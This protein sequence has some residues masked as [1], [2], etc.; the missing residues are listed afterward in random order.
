M[1][2]FGEWAMD[3]AVIGTERGVRTQ[4]SPVPSKLAPP[5]LPSPRFKEMIDWYK[6]VIGAEA[7]C[8][9]EGLAFLTYDEEHHR[10]AITNIPHLEGI[11]LR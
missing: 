7:S 4:V 9:N 11:P 10:V 3:S 5:A 2:K 8:E 1:E 6:V